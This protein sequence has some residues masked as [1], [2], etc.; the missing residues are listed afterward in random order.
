MVQFV[1]DRSMVGLRHGNG[2]F[3]FG[4][5]PDPDMDRGNI[6]KV[7]KHIGLVKLSFGGGLRSL[8]EI[9]TLSIRS[10]KCSLPRNDTQEKDAN[11]G[12]VIFAKLILQMYEGIKNKLQQSLCE[13]ET[14]AMT[15]E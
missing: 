7:K 10:L 1:R 12:A 3:N 8:S 9:Y 5:D 11:Y 2:Q 4:R 14:V 13:A 15:T 6:F